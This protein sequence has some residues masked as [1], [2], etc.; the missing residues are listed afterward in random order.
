M[1]HGAGQP[2]AAHERSGAQ[3]DQVTMTQ[4]ESSSSGAPATSSIRAAILLGHAGADDES[5][6]ITGVE[7]K[8]HQLLE[9]FAGA[10]IEPYVVY[11]E[12]GRQGATFAAHSRALLARQPEKRY[13]AAFVNELTSFLHQHDIDVV[14]SIGMR[15]DFH[16]ALACRR[17]RLPHV[18]HRPVALADE[19]MPAWRRVLYGIP[20]TWTLLQCREIVAC[21]QASALR[22][23]QTQGLP[24]AKLVVVPNG[25]AFP[26]VSTSERQAARAAMGISEDSLMVVGVGQLIPRKAFHLLVQALGHIAPQVGQRV[27]CILLGEGPER[28]HLVDMARRHEVTLHL[29]GFVESPASLVAAADISV[30]PSLAEG[31]PRVVLEAMSVGVPTIAT[32]VAGTP[33]V[34]EDGVSGLLVPPN[35]VAAIASAL[36]RL[37]QDP[38]LR[39]RLGRVGQETVRTRF[40]PSAMVE[41]FIAS[42]QRNARV[43]HPSTHGR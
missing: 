14:M 2:A 38:A 8:V 22:M 5:Y 4:A 24:A 12:R 29:P 36:L 26:E 34:I 40:R 33:E 11:P 15:Q 28:A 3:E 31:M 39:A 18:V 32:S 20:D 23:R 30:L 43:R 6:G 37:A 9:G 25:V 35:N 10:S 27:E 1:H 41:G 7:R 19:T 42:L 21:S 16:A 13:D 17:L